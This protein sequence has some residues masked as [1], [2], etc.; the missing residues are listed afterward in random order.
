MKLPYRDF[1]WITEEERQLLEACF[2]Y[3]CL[4]LRKPNM[5]KMNFEDA[6]P[7]NQGFFIEC[8]LSYP[9]RYFRV[10][11]ETNF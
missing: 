5:K 3:K 10:K 4:L 1:K 2:K 7:S 9:K 8:D 6:F 11:Y